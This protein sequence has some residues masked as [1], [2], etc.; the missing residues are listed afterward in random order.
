MD[1]CSRLDFILA[2]GVHEGCSL[3]R[4]HK[5]TKERTISE[6]IEKVSIWRSLYNG[7]LDDSNT[8]RKMSLDEAAKRV[9]VL[10]KSLDDYLMQL[11]YA[12]ILGF[13]FQ[14]HKD[15]KIGVLRR[16]VKAGRAKGELKTK[17]TR[18]DEERWPLF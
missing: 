1:S 6:V 5:R 13:D 2:S 8:M 11:R 4:T 9:G 12:K 18:G 16:F 15:D 10:K 17:R 14:K 7:G 3:G